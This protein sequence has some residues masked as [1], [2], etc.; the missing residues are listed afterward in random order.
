MPVI[1]GV[2]QEMTLLIPCKDLMFYP[3]FKLQPALRLTESSRLKKTARP[4]SPSVI[5]N[6]KIE[7][8]GIWFGLM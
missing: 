8:I 7:K 3:L 6:T 5:D 4:S 2:S 1:R